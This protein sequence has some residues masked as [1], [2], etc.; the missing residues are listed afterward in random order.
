MCK[1]MPVI[2]VNRVA[3][4]KRKMKGRGGGEAQGVADPPGPL[5]PPQKK[6]PLKA[7]LHFAGLVQSL[8]LSST[9]RKRKRPSSASTGS[10]RHRSQL[11]VRRT[12]FRLDLLV[13]CYKPT[14]SN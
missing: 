2:S 6:E 1:E 4:P 10:P 7:D 14:F 3:G 12:S 11:P 5:P 8:A 9:S 13:P